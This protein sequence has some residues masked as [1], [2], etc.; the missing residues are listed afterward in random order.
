M[1]GHVTVAPGVA[2]TRGK[3]FVTW[4]TVDEKHTMD[5]DRL[6]VRLIRDLAARGT[7]VGD[8]DA[9]QGA[10]FT[11]HP[12]RGRFLLSVTLDV[13]HAGVMAVLGGGGAL[14][15]IS[16]PFDVTDAA[17]TAPPITLAVAHPPEPERCQG[18]GLTLE[19]IEAPMVAGTVGNPTSRRAC[20][21][22]PRDYADHPARRYPVIYALPGLGGTD[23]QILGRAA[24]SSDAA[25]VVMVDT[26]TKT[27]STYL[28]DSPITGAWD[29]F[30]AKDL[31]PYIDAHYRTLPRRTARGLVGHSTGGFN[32]M[33]Y[34]LRHPELFSAIGASSPDALD[35]TVWIGHTVPRWIL[36]WQRVEREF[37]GPGNFVSYSADWSPNAHGYDWGFDGSGA[38][39]DSVFQ[40][41][42]PNVPATWLRDP[43][44]VAA[45]RPFSDHIYLTVGD[46]DEFDLHAP[47]VAFS[48][49]L[50]TVGIRNQ[51]VVTHGGHFTH[52]GE[53][54]DEATKFCANHLDAAK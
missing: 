53:Q 3:L 38:V 6:P 49:E 28:V 2:A 27:G 15:G 14:Q 23:Q 52:L 20:V 33:S 8:V 54:L 37:D 24:V 43:Q 48:R 41:W 19:R 11:V 51:L 1:T 26:S 40:R 39:I 22:V 9:A 4:M 21:R 29:T 50:E 5:T 44:R 25:I 46:T 47:A 18:P 36:G 42:L 35:F 12:G 17:V 16:A 7:V 13:G 34:G 32:A 31:V 30:F 45:L 10:T